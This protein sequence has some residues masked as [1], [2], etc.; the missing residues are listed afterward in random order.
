MEN[1]TLEKNKILEE[2][3][4]YISLKFKKPKP[5]VV[6]IGIAVILVIFALFFAKGLFVAATVNGN[7]ISRWSIIKELE[8]QSGKQALDKFIT[9]KLIEDEVKK[10][11]IVVEES[12]ITGEFQVIESQMAA[13]GSTLKDQLL[14]QGMTE[15]DL[16]DRL[17]AHLQIE[18][19]LGDKIQVSE[20]EIDAYVKTN[21]ITLE[22]GK[23]TEMRTKLKEQ[24]KEDK[25]NQQ[26]EQYIAEL[27]E[28]AKIKYYVDY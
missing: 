3:K 17:R 19:L 14:Q 10:Q 4:S 1:T 24:I 6:M 12:E 5:L 23:E 25:V 15:Q 26:A 27:R 13:M 11:G 20:A 2:G 28:S 9:E 7:S 18:K 16:K 8:R 21:K 22:K